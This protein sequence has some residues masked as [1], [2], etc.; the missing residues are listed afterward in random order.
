MTKRWG[1]ITWF[2][3]HSF[4]E[5]IEDSAFLANRHKYL[6]LILNLCSNLPC[7]SCSVHAKT[8]LTRNRFLTVVKNRN[9]LRLFLWKF[10]NAVNTRLKKEEQP[11]SILKMYFNGNFEEIMSLFSKEF[12]QPISTNN[13]LSLMYKNIHAQELLNI[14]KAN[15][16]HFYK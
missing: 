9:D 5:K 13:I 11:V 2:F 10:H 14:I 1:P 4:A 8:Y 6:S 12:L 15:K 7:P 3:L 16:R